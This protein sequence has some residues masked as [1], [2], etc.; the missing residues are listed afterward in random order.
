MNQC[1]AVIGCRVDR[2]EF[3]CC[4]LDAN[5][6]A[7]RPLLAIDKRAIGMLHPGR[8]QHTSGQ[9]TSGQHTSGQRGC[10]AHRVIRAVA[11]QTNSKRVR[12]LSDYAT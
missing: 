6:D 1:L 9:H 8:G 12:M 4:T 11:T 7:V 5:C 2:T 3:N 10:Y